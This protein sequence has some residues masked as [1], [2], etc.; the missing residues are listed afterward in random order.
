MVPNDLIE[1]LV[2]LDS[3]SWSSFVAEHRPVVVR[4]LSRLVGATD[5]ASVADLEQE[6]YVRLLANDR[7]PLRRLRSA[8]DGSLRAFVCTT[9]A[10]VARDHR[11]RLQVRGHMRAVDEEGS[12]DGLFVAEGN[13][14]A[15]A[16]ARLRTSEVLDVLVRVVKEPNAS[17]DC[18]IFKA[19][20]VDGLT[21]AEI[22]ALGLGIAPKGVE[23][24]LYRLTSKVR[25]ALGSG[26]EKIS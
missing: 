8:S 10:N 2:R 25:E 15:A 19:H 20:Y 21:A 24:V 1:G 3:A 14:E 12:E 23:A 7:G 17:R 13:G 22:G 4:I 5:P 18:L 11:R 9:A 6:V 26:E 16:F